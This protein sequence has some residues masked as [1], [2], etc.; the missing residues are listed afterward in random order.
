MNPQQTTWLAID[1]TAL[2]FK[3]NLCYYLAKPHVRAEPVLTSSDSPQAPD[4]FA[5]HFYGTVLQDNGKFRMWYYPASFKGDRPADAEP[6]PEWIDANVRQGPVCYA[7]SEDGIHWRKPVLDQFD[8]KGSRA[9]NAINLPDAYI[10]GASIIKDEAD[11]DPSRRYKL[12]YNAWSKRGYATMRTAVSPDGIKWTPG[13]EDP[14]QTFV[15]QCSLYKHDGLY[16]VSAQVISPYDRSE[17][18]ARCGRVARTFV[19]PNFTH[20]VQESAESF[21]MTEPSDPAERGHDKPYEQIHMGV[22]AY[23]LGNVLVGISCR[24]HNRPLT[25]DWFGVGTTSGDFFL[26]ISND[27]LAFREPV[28][29]H[30]YL[31]RSDSPLAPIPG[32]AYETVLCQGNGII[33]V[34]DETRIYHGRWRNSQ[35][36]RY[37]GSE[38]ALATLPRDR[39][40][41]LGLFPDKEA[42]TVW[43][44]PIAAKSNAQIALNGD[45]VAGMKL[46]IADEHFNLIPQYSGTNA[47]TCPHPDGL[48]CPVEWPTANIEATAGK[49]IRL[50][51]QLKRGK[52]AEPR[53]FA[54]YWK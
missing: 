35:D 21:A 25:G 17:G 19:S 8:F 11:S 12:V 9:N 53:L 6:T 23:S 22:G 28:K 36:P 33:T 42:G 29:G 34:G 13:P 41:A 20:W 50:R 44:A 46:E 16:M 7:E 24:W 10:A 43:S 52:Y 1:D 38:V 51:L 2:R 31:S 54:I 45:G 5:A 40:G 49:K 15:E 14:I 30:V 32:V 39:W 4:H 26:V 37:Q 48:H 27:G 3:K 18:G 47:G